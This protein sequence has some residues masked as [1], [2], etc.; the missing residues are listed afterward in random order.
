[1]TI[2]IAYATEADIDDVA[3]LFEQYRSFYGKAPTREARTFL[4]ERVSSGQSLVLLARDGYAVVG[5]V[6]VYRAFNSIHLTHD[7]VLGD[8]FVDGGARGRRVGGGLVDAVITAARENDAHS[9]R[10]ETEEDNGYAR[11]L[12]ESRG[13]TETGDDGRLVQ[14]SLQL[15]EHH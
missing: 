2:E 1:M 7:W 15:R 9:I 13:F 6:Q 3:E 10:V 4:A 11:R 12:Y 5:F 14:Y 8:L